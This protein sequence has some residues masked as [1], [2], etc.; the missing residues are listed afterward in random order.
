MRIVFMGTPDFAVPSLQAILKSTHEVA[1]VVTAPDKPRGRGQKVSSTPVKQCA[2]EHSLP[3][4]QPESVKAPEFVEAL[5]TVQADCYVVVAFKILPP[6][7]FNIPPKGTFNL[8]ASLLPR[9]RGA[10]P[11]NWALMRGEEESGVTT[12][13]ID[14]KVDTGNILLKEA[15]PIG[16]DMT[17]G[18]LHDALSALGANAIVKTLDGLESGSLSPK[19][20]DDTE[21]TPAPKIWRETC[22]IDWSKPAE[23]I[24]N[25][26]RG[27]SPYPGAWTML[28]ET[29][30]KILRSAIA[31]TEGQGN[32]GAIVAS[33]DS[34]EVECADGRIEVVELQMQGKKVLRADAFLRGYTFPEGSTFE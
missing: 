31:S 14:E 8:H 23:E 27:L 11:I 9:F 3:L 25:H 7:V 10:A 1:A 21:A 19:P 2:E 18:E 12:F 24:H 20:Q 30:F 13:L 4:I 34:I 6:E 29:Q 33:R 26:I 32:P 28:G 5:H 22:R 15:I 16:K 17:A